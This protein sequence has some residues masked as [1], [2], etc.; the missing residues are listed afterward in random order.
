MYKRTALFL[1]GLSALAACQSPRAYAPVN[2]GSNPMLS[3]QNQFRNFNTN[4]D[5]YSQL[6]PELQAYYAPA[7]GLQG[8]ALFEAL[9]QIINKARQLD[10]GPGKSYL[11]A[12]AANYKQ[13]NQS[14]L[15]AVYSNMFVAGSGGD[16]GRYTERGDQNG[17]GKGGDFI[18]CEHTWPQS[19]F[20]K[21]EPMRSDV[22]HLFPTFSVPNNRRG[23]HPFGMASEGKVVY[24]TDSG[25][26]LAL[27]GRALSYSNAQLSSMFAE[28]DQV[29]AMNA[30]NATEATEDDIFNPLGKG[31]AVYEPSNNQKGNTARA[32]LYFY[33]R[34]YN[35]NIRQG[36]Y[37]AKDYLVNRLPMFAEWSEKVDPV[38][39]AERRRNDLIAQE[40]GNRNP[41]VDIPNLVNLIGLDTFKQVES[42]F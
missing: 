8:R 29:S 32:T 4:A 25:S 27:R 17:D 13:G 22:H 24:S 34:F 5:W 20:G 9:H 36:D 19:F 1:L 2:M 11:Y 23:H 18:N 35:R 28:T 26:K 38:D 10:Y 33:M 21:D 14:G 15:D 40:Q 12:V 37:D 42:Q 6:S 16:G 31:E 39:A 30:M 7:K 41:F 3:A